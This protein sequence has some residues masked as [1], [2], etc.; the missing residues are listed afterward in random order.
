MIKQAKR[1]DKSVIETTQNDIFPIVKMI[2]R[3]FDDSMYKLSRSLDK[4]IYWLHH[5]PEGDLFSERER[6]DMC[7][8]LMELKEAF[9]EQQSK[10]D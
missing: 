9:F 1:L 10:Q 8:A 7:F 5:I 6:Q 4:S 3:Y 2:N